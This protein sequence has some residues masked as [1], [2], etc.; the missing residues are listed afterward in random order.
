MEIINK[1]K[2]KLQK[3]TAI[4]ISNFQSSNQNQY[5]QTCISPIKGDK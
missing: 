4:L 2:F 5:K 3:Q 1:G